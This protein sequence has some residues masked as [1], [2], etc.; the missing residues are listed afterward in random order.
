MNPPQ[1]EELTLW[2]F[3]ASNKYFGIM[4]H[5]YARDEADAHEQ[6]K[7]WIARYQHLPYLEVKAY[8]SGFCVHTRFLPGKV[9]VPVKDKE[10]RV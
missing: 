5:V 6:A 8:P 7:D 10:S 2:M 4:R 9:L 3:N 1:T